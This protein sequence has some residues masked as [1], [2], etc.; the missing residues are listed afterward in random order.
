MPIIATSIPNPHY[1]EHSCSPVLPS[2]ALS[3]SLRD[4]YLSQFVTVFEVLES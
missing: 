4:R 1:I 3:V 2:S